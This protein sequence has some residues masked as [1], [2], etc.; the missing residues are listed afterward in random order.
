M[1]NCWAAQQI[2][3]PKIPMA[4]MPLYEAIR[5]YCMADLRALLLET[6]GK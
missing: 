1:W 4:Q 3:Y 5:K 6:A 2:C